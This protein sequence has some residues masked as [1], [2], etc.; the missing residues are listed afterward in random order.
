[1]QNEINQ[2]ACPFCKN[3]NSCQAK[4]SSPCWCYNAAIPTEL[5]ALVPITLK[6]KSCICFTCVN[7]FKENPT[8]FKNTYLQPIID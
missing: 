6:N 5:T 8:Q 1:M 7:L 4:G 3:A 2:E